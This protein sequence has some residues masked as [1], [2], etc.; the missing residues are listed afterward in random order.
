ME[1]YEVISTNLDIRDGEFLNVLFANPKSAIDY[2]AQELEDKNPQ[3]I[4]NDFEGKLSEYEGKSLQY[5]PC[6]DKP[7]IY[8]RSHYANHRC[9][10]FVETREVN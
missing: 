5:T 3:N 8:Y 10:I 4:I 2:C 9:A 6:K 1:I 7:A